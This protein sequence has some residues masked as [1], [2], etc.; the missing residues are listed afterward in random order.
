MAFPYRLTPRM[1]QNL[2]GFLKKYH[3]LFSG[4]RCS[5]W[6]LEELV[7]KAVQSDTQK[8]HH[9]QWKEGGHD[10][11]EDIQ[12]KTN[13]ETHS[14]QIKSGQ[15]RNS[16]LIISGNRLGRFEKDF[17]QITNFL[18]TKKDNIISIPY[19]VTDDEKGRTHHYKIAYIDVDLIRG[20]KQTK[21][22]KKGK[23]YIQINTK[24]VEFSL[25]PSMSWQI[26]WKIPLSS[27]EIKNL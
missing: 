16:H 9:I 17:K 11:N 15:I 6:E 5:G 25:R 24:G 23:Q 3:D 2:S 7:V 4:G 22:E 20:I 13:G 19:Q 26:W 12:V 27:I 8:N 10:F 1:L 21:W 14:I 18:N